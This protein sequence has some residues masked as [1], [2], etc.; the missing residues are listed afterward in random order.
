MMTPEAVIEAYVSDVARRLPRAKRGDVALELQ[1][2]LGDELSGKAEMSGRAADEAMALELVRT[3]GSPEEV[4]E[5]YRPAG[6]TIVPPTR[7]AR[8]A[9]IALSGVV[10]QWLVTLPVALLKE[11][12]RELVMLGSWW[13]SYGI[14]ALWWPGFMVTA[15]I[16]GGWMRH[17]WPPAHV[18]TWRPS[19]RDRDEI[20]RTMWVISSVAAGFG[21]AALVGAPWIAE[22]YLPPA[23][24]G[25]FRF[26][27][28]F[29]ALG[30]AL[31]VAMWTLT[32]LSGAIVFFEGRWRPLTRQIDLALTLLWFVVLTWLAMGPRAFVN[33]AADEAAKFWVGV[34]AVLV[35]IDLAVKVYRTLQRPRAAAAL[36]AIAKT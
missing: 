29:L 35:L 18:S 9:A 8:F 20:N 22:N 5:R 7:S 33:D 28:D 24:A 14:G 12:G 32:A 10:L 27:A 36:V 4:A 31:V 30:G 23:A 19:A 34:V 16:V 17:R 15:A 2:L 13:L 21:I 3:F 11:P 26:D 25:V 1:A 6:F